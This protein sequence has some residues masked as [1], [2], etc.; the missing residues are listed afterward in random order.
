MSSAVRVT[1][2]TQITTPGPQGARAGLQTQGTLRGIKLTRRIFS[3][4]SRAEP[5]DVLREVEARR[6]RC[7]DLSWLDALD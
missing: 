3:A 1:L 6:Q 7:R 4:V 5:K 2:T